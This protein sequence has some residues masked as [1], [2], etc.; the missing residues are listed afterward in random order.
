MTSHSD[1]AEKIKELEEALRASSEL[2]HEAVTAFVRAGI[3]KALYKLKTDLEG[4]KKEE[5]MRYW[6][7]GMQLAVTMVTDMLSHDYEE[8]LQ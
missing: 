6:V 5:D 7:P 2:R 1:L 3:A 8:D 4:L